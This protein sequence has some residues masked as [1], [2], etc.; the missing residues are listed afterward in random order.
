LLLN[1]IL[2][3]VQS[4]PQGGRLTIAA[5]ADK[6]CLELTVADCGMGIEP[7]K[8]E[9]IFEPYFTTKTTGSGLGLSISR[10]IAEAHGG[11]ITVNRRSERGSRFIV[12]LPFS[13]PE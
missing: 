10:R 7:D 11:T 2:N 12:R 4:M 8:L 5:G 3:G 6:D 1:L 13:A 9:K